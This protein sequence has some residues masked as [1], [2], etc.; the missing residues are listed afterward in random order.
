MT[1][2]LYLFLLIPLF[3]SGCSNGPDAEKTWDLA[4]E[5]LFSAAISE[6]GNFAILGST[7]GKALIWD[8]KHP[9]KPLHVLQ[10]KEKDP[11]G[12]IAVAITPDHKFALTAERNSLAWWEVSTS[13]ILGYW[14]IPEIYSLSISPDGQR[15]LIGLKD[16]AFYFSLDSGTYLHRLIHEGHLYATAL[17]DDGRF[18]LTGSDRNNS[19]LWSLKT[20]KMKYNWQ[21]KT[22]L[23]AVA[24]SANGKKAMTN[25]AS[26][27]TEIHSTST[28]KVLRNLPP[29][30]ITI[31]SA[32]FSP[33]GNLLA[34]G[35]SSNRIDLWDLKEGTVKQHWIAKK[36][37]T[38]RPTAATII[39]LEFTHRGKRITSVTSGGIVQRWK[40][41]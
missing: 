10:H 20:G 5:G 18:A 38:L 25:S 11:E 17:S 15:A 14:P 33:K 22:K 6:D 39:A 40:I 13:T 31:T 21:H 8:L 29:E 24:L 16:Q 27:M 2:R 4:P 26:G 34:T 23:Y 28:G 12:I 30:R 3:L 19:K 9:K 32:D 7:S 37:D 1:S 41:D 36:T 35:R